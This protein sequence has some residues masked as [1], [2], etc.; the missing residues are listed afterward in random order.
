MG[1][2]LE[3]IQSK[4]VISKAGAG[5]LKS[6]KLELHLQKKKKDVKDKCK[7]DILVALSLSKP[8]VPVMVTDGHPPPFDIASRHLIEV[9]P[10]G[11]PLYCLSLDYCDGIGSPSVCVG[12]G[13][14]LF[15]I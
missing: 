7:Y 6:W 9:G 5:C 1:S 4:P 13:G 11:P 3:I 2:Q 14:I 12:T 8:F 10:E 15:K